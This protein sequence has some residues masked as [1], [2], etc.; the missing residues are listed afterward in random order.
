MRGVNARSATG[1]AAGLALFGAGC[2]SCEAPRT[3]IPE[4]R[5]PR[6]DRPPTIDGDLSDWAG[7]AR[8]EVFVDTMTGAR[9]RLAP[10]ARMMWDERA[11]YVAFEVNDR[12]LRASGTE[13]D[14]HLWEQDCVELMFD[15][16]GDEERYLELQ[17]SPRNVVFDTYFDSYRAP[18]PFGHVGWSSG[19]ESAVRLRGG[20]DDDAPDE[21]Y[22]VELR[23]PWSAFT[24][25]GR[26]GG[27]PSAGET[28]RVAL[29]VLDAHEGGQSGVGWSPPL[30]GD[31]HVP[32]RFGRIVFEP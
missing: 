32:S 20:I 14:D 6:A 1:L 31:F 24:V 11:L 13:H 25:A 12:L 19:L 27:P 2:T 10:T 30:V 28:F 26:D 4:L 17:V 9:E 8:T 3:E 21:G 7:A 23:I 15:P 22:D 16:D 5:V 18:R 29:Y